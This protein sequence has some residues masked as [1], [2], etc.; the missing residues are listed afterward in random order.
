MSANDAY[1]QNNLDDLPGYKLVT[2][3]RGNLL[4]ANTLAR[5]DF[6]LEPG[7]TQGPPLTTLQQLF[8][9]R[10]E[11]WSCLLQTKESELVLEEIL[12][13]GQGQELRVL[14]RGKKQK[15]E[16]WFWLVSDLTSVQDDR[17][18][19]IDYM[20][21][22]TS[23]QA[24]IREYARQIEVFRKIVDGMEQG[25]VLTNEAGQLTFANS[26]AEKL[27]GIPLVNISPESW[28]ALIT[29]VNEDLG[30]SVAPQNHPKGEVLVLNEPQNRQIRCY[31][32]VAP[33]T[34]A[35]SE[36]HLVWTLF[37]LTEEIANTQAFIDFSTELSRL[38]REL[39]HKNAEILKLMNTDY[40]TGISNRLT[41]MSVLEKEA[42]VVNRTGQGEFA[43]MLF[44]A[45]HFKEV[46]DDFGHLK[47]DE[48]LK[49]LAR[50]ARDTV[51]DQGLVGRYGG[52][53]FLVVTPSLNSASA[54]LLAQRL[55]ESA[56]KATVQ[57]GVKVSITIGLAFV[58]PGRSVRDV[59]D[60]ADKALYRGKNLGR[61][62]VITAE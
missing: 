1:L 34:D 27:F 14:L 37:E 60:A 26:F 19:L 52:E 55:L 39:E 20:A 9:Y 49:A 10:E 30:K 16:V 46:N 54:E 28:Q 35:K 62:Q 36:T 58:R 12:H 22:I 25:I 5:T 18:G 15:S 56:V 61:N 33:L 31:L 21:D 11:D 7:S 45:D 13:G 29:P 24:K 53:E 38:N 51:G 42:E 48:V 57:T 43:I 47:G 2:D 17:Q 59:L 40:L 6:G 8:P 50:S 3:L 41:V 4:Q 23:T 32:N 44:D